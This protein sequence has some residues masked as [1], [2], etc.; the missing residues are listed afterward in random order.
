[1]DNPALMLVAIFF[2]APA[3]G[4]ALWGTYYLLVKSGWWKALDIPQYLKFI[5]IGMTI[6]A[7]ASLTGLVLI[8]TGEL[9]KLNDQLREC[10]KEQ[11]NHG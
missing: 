8:Q 3:T 7:L 1:M 2:G 5:L 11:I 4:F 10:G 9:N 6:S